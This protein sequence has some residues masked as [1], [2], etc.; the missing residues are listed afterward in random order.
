MKGGFFRNLLEEGVATSCHPFSEQGHRQERDNPSP[1][2]LKIGG[3]FDLGEP[4]LALE[5]QLDLS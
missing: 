4:P 3:H 1:C 5:K 2:F